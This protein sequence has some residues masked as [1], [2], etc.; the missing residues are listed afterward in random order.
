MLRLNFA[1]SWLWIITTWIALLGTFL[2]GLYYLTGLWTSVIAL[3]V[4]FLIGLGYLSRPFPNISLPKLSRFDWLWGASAVIIEGALLATLYT[5]RTYDVLNSPWRA[6]PL[7][8][9]GLYFI[10]TI[11]AL[12]AP[13][14]IRSRALTYATTALH[15]F[16]TF[17]VTLIM[18]PLGFGFDGFIHR[19]TEDWI[20]A[21]GFI[22]PK[23]PVY[24][25]Q[26]TLVV[27]LAKITQLPIHLIDNWFVPVLA[28]L[29]L[30]ALFQR[31]F[32]RVW[33]FPNALALN[34][35][36]LYPALYFL[37]LGLTTPYNFLL[38]IITASICAV[39]EW[40]KGN[41]SAIVPISLGLLGLFT[42]VMLGAPL[43]LLIAAALI[44]HKLKNGA[45]TSLLITY[46]VAAVI[47]V[48]ALFTLYLLAKHLPWPDFVN[49]FTKIQHFLDLYKL[50]FWYNRLAPHAWNYFY[51]LEWVFAPIITGL[52]SIGWWFEP[53]K[54]F[55][56][57]LFPITALAFVAAAILLRT[58]IVFPDVHSFEQ[59]DYPLR[60][61][62]ASLLWILPWAGAG[63]G[64][65]YL[66]IKKTKAAVWLLPSVLICAALG[67]T[68]AFYF[69][70][71][72]HNK[73]VNFP[74][75]NVTTADL[76][77]V[78]WIDADNNH[79]KNIDYIVLANPVVGAAALSQFSF[80]KYYDTVLGQYSYYSIPSGS[81]LFSFY[82]DMWQKPNTTTMQ[83]AMDL[84]GVKKA[85]FV[86]NSYWVNYPQ[87][88]AQA[89][90]TTDVWTSINGDQIHVFKYEQK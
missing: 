62:R 58:W 25:G 9:F 38:L 72:Q 45:Q 21:H 41:V 26:Y 50:P 7:W 54:K 6:L 18:Y 83:Q 13:W 22:L 42:H 65:L 34:L 85:Y 80:A 63:I 11:I 67:L 88:V 39:L 69:S 53:H 20:A 73:K 35:T 23:Q 33:N 27:W 64:A 14:F 60:L 30:P 70:Y 29:A 75:F 57:W 61:L 87:I 52:A 15:L 79:T 36:W 31:L 2:S 44:G 59:G 3:G 68:I 84:F 66:T 16:T 89:K 51:K 81:P 86:I 56:R 78:Q 32:T 19:A 77:A 55:G 40:Q 5:H 4:V 8:F 46:T 82:T 37:W 17:G 24:I 47:T 28:S 43:A 71:P 12:A 49:P 10:G 48:P 74:G 1:K 90:T 76:Q